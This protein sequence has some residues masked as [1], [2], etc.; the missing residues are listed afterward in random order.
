MIRPLS[1]LAVVVLLTAC[2]TSMMNQ[3]TW[4][5]E[6]QRTYP[7]G[8]PEAEVAA[9]ATANGMTVSD[10][11]NAFRTLPRS[12]TGDGSGYW[13]TVTKQE[14]TPGCAL[15][16]TAYMRFDDD[17]NLMTVHPGDAVCA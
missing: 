15:R 12:V 6:M 2:G 5:A 11:P 7:P 4:I 17:G 13:R 3:Q 9:G 16:R 1:A 14:S 8:T 10:A